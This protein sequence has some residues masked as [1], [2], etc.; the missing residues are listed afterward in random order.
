MLLKNSPPGRQLTTSLND[1]WPDPFITPL[2]GGKQPQPQLEVGGHERDRS[3]DVAVADLA[4]VAAHSVFQPLHF[5]DVSC[6]VGSLGGSV[7]W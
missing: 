1:I 7:C 3:G 2:P 5:S 4:S 6:L